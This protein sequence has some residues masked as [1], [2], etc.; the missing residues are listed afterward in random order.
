MLWV[1]IAADRHSQ[2]HG[3]MF[4]KELPEDK[5]MVFAFSSPQVLKFWGLNTFIP[6]DIAFVDEND[7]IVK[8]D[9]IKPNS[10][11]IVSSEA[12][13]AIAI[14]A[15][16]GFFKSH[17]INVGDKIVVEKDSHKGTFIKFEST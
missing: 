2:E 15:N 6:L 11:K 16:E 12:K 1:D 17:N 3:L 9:L 14:E 13:C 5:G 10:M 4:R 8:I 7:C